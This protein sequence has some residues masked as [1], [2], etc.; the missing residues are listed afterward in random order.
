MGAVREVRNRY[1]VDSRTPLDVSVRCAP[2]VAADFQTL[3]LFI[4][5][6]AGVGSLQCGPDATRLPQ[7]VGEVRPRFEAF[8]SLRG[9]IDM[10]AE[11]KR[12][13]KQLAEKEKY[14]QSAEAKLAN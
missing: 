6:L 3:A 13:E 11:S 14:L 9:L 8:V 2:D 10:A 12:M 1:K 5:A 4:T 7:S